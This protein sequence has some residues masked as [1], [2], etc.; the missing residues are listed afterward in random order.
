MAKSHVQ[1]TCQQC[2]AIYKNWTGRCTK[3]GAWSSLIQQF[4]DNSRDEKSAV[5]RAQTSGKTLE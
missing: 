5:G 4:D 1:F 3:C 2:G